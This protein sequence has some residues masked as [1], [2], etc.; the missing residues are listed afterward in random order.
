MNPH[1]YSLLCPVSQSRCLLFR[2]SLDA[3]IFECLSNVGL[4]QLVAK[5]AYL[6]RI[7]I[8]VVLLMSCPIISRHDETECEAVL[9]KEMI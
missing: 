3:Q 2:W 4:T 7:H 1:L 6:S 8:G 5:L 9:G